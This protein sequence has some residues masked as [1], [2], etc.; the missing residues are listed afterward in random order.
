MGAGASQ[1]HV[2]QQPATAVEAKTRGGATAASF[3]LVA[4][5]VGQVTSRPPKP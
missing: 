3:E 5:M 2:A 4:K 1:Q